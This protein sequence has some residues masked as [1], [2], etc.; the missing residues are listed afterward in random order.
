MAG[1]CDYAI[2]KDIL[3]NCDDPIIPG[4]LSFQEW[5]RKV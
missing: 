1:V 5:N 3:V 2:K 4:M